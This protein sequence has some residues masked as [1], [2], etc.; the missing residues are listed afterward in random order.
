M[1]KTHKVIGALLLLVISV[2]TIAQDAAPKT[3]RD[4]IELGNLR[5]YYSGKDRILEGHAT[6][7]EKNGNVRIRNFKTLRLDETPGGEQ[8][9]YVYFTKPTDLVG[10]TFLVHKNPGEDDDRWLFLPKL[11]LVRRISAG[12]KRTHFVGTDIFYEDVSGRHLDDDDHELIEESDKYWIVTSKPKESNSVEFA[13]YKS[14]VHKK[15]HLIIKRQ[16]FDAK[17]NLYREFKVKKVKT[18]AGIPTTFKTEVTDHNRGT[19]TVVDCLY[20]EYSAGLPRDLFEKPY[21]RNPP[22]EWLDRANEDKK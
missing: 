1:F 12:D 4:V 8:Y 21:L 7:T 19:Q 11:D 14:W 13:Y 16:F 5:A 3:G 2:F 9:Y 22:R 15:T 17:D 10:T 6:V 20:L 18:V